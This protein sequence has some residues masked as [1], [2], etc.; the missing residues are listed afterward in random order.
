VGGG[1]AH[2]GLPTRWAEAFAKRSGHSPQGLVEVVSM[3]GREL[4]AF[5]IV[6]CKPVVVATRW[7]HSV[8]AR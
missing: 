2:T 1:R 6:P 8:V 3:L 4:S 5:S 7:R